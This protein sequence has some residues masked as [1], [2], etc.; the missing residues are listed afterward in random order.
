M[1]KSQSQKVLS[2]NSE[3]TLKKENQK[4]KK[5]V[6]TLEE[7]IQRLNERMEEMD[8]FFRSKAKENFEMFSEYEKYGLKKIQ[9]ENQNKINQLEK[10]LKNKEEESSKYIEIINDLKKKSTDM[11]GLYKNYCSKLDTLINIFNN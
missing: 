5:K 9:S 4:L 6:T 10:E 3:E 8:Q 11:E 1:K 7:T 2:N